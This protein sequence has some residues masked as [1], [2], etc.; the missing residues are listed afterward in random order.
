MQ[1]ERI[2]V[3]CPYHRHGRLNRVNARHHGLGERG[4]APSRAMIGRRMGNDDSGGVRS[5]E[6][7]STPEPMVIRRGWSAT[8]LQTAHGDAAR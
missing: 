6:S 2:V 1:R 8:L 5:T 3:A 7:R 4:H